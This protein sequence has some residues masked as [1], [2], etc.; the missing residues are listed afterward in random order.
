LQRLSKQAF[1]LGSISTLRRAVRSSLG[2]GGRL[3]GKGVLG[4][5]WG[6]SAHRMVLADILIIF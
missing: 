1:F 6:G 2:M 4:Q 5:A 3:L